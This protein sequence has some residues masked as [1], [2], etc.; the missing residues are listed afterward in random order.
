MERINKLINHPLYKEYIGKIES[1]E[2]QREFCRHDRKHFLDVSR[3]AYLFYLEEKE[4]QES[5]PYT[6]EQVRELLYAAGLLHDIGR[7]QQYEE[8][9]EHHLASVQLAVP[10]LQDSDFSKEEGEEICGIILAH[11]SKEEGQSKSL[12]GIFY[13]ADKASRE[14]FWCQA[15]DKCNWKKEKMNLRI[16]I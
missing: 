14:C 3:I 7:W 6:K 13:R 10:L 9:I 4:L 5:L 1:Y 11:R 16:W 8:N 12:K 15:I 2:C